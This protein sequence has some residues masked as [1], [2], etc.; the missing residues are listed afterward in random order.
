[1]YDYIHYRSPLG[2]LTVTA[3]GG[4]LT[5]LVPAYDCKIVLFMV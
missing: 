5:A 3:E 2:M 1:M 4:T